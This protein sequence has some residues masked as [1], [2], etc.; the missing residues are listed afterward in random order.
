[1]SCPMPGEFRRDWD[2]RKVLHD[3][4]TGQQHDDYTEVV[5]VTI[6]PRPDRLS[7]FSHC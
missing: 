7:S 3:Y 2:S 6:C 5:A 1:M 4:P